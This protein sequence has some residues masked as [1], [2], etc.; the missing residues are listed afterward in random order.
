[1]SA[2]ETSL[3][4]AFENLLTVTL[5]IK[6]V[7]DAAAGGDPTLRELPA[8]VVRA[9]AAEMTTAEHGDPTDPIDTEAA[10]A[11][12]AMDEFDRRLAA[13]A[14]E[15]A[16]GIAT[17][18]E[19]KGGP[20]GP[21]DAAITAQP[22]RRKAPIGVT[23]LAWSPEAPEL[24][25]EVEAE[26][27][28]AGGAALHKFTSR[29]FLYGRFAT[30]KLVNMRLSTI[31]ERSRSLRG[32]RELNVSGNRLRSLANLPAEL[33][34]L[35]AFGNRISEIRQEA[36]LSACVHLGLGYNDLASCRGV[37]AAFPALASLD[38][39]WNRIESLDDATV[40]AS[41]SPAGSG[42]DDASDTGLPLLDAALGGDV[43]GP[44]VCLTGATSWQ[45][46]DALA[47][48]G[49]D[50]TLIA[51]RPASRADASG[52]GADADADADEAAGGGAAGPGVA[53]AG[54]AQDA[55]APT[56]TDGGAS[57]GSGA[58]SGAVES[59]VIGRAL[60]AAAGLLEVGDTSDSASVVS[61]ATL[62]IEQL[63]PTT[64]A[65][66][67]EAAEAEMKKELA[68]EAAEAAGG[69]KKKPAKGKAEAPPP[70]TEE[71]RAE[72][73]SRAAAA[74]RALC[75]AASATVEVELR[76][77]E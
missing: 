1:M 44:V 51:E 48:N 42:S 39:S 58:T 16:G 28:R 57:G 74:C 72:A 2:A 34:S 37:P 73:A 24:L 36:P 27:S 70:L 53:T 21:I 20:A 18:P 41:S 54:A 71:Q 5:G 46:R 14:A 11:M 31:D 75:R 13:G 8:S 50:V 77:G 10:E 61:R 35:Q 69:G 17:A 67:A 15:K 68:E 19:R 56:G 60:V 6:P 45:L 22:V 76:L 64:R 59:V 23:G 25:R 26:R 63:P 49:I 55:E 38:L 3:S 40:G 4:G 12:R 66:A 32:L 52:T 30:L 65:A 47:V 33:E 62:R 9:V 7:R 43:P 29:A